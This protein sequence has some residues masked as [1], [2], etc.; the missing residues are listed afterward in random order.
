MA[1]G[2]RQQG[3]AGFTC[4]LSFWPWKR[5]L[6]GG[7]G[8]SCAQG[9]AVGLQVLV[10]GNGVQMMS[11]GSSMT[12]V[13]AATGMHTRML[14]WLGLHPWGISLFAAVSTTWKAVKGFGGARGRDSQANSELAEQTAA[15]VKQLC[16]VLVS[17]VNTV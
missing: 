10:N 5:S 16:P 15:K 8:S 9:Q 14:D 7:G 13:L 6:G 11:E 12:L 2:L 1:K 4:S 17:S 3:R